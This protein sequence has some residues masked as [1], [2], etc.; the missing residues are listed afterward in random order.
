MRLLILED[1]PI[2]IE[3]FKKLFKNQEIVIFDNVDDAIAACEKEEFKVL[4]LDHDLDNKIW[5]DSHSCHNTGYKFVY[6]LIFKGL[7][8]N[9]LIY[10]HS[11]NPVG[12]NKMLNMLKD[13]DYDGIWIPFHLLKLEDK[14][15]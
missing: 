7:Q 4:W 12:A 3:K 9:S 8:K 2:R 11:M 1:N 5:V 10:I 13:N 14:N 15:G 6:T